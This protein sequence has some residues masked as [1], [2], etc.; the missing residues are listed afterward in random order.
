[1]NWIREDT[2]VLALIAAWMG[3]AVLFIN[4]VGQ[5]ETRLRGDMAEIRADFRELR[6]RVETIIENHGERITRLESHDHP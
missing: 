6:T 4:F 2:G 1:M 5:S 3:T